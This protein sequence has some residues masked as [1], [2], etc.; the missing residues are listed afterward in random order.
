MGEEEG[1][2]RLGVRL[3]ASLHHTIEQQAREHHRSLNSEIITLL[4][5]GLR[6]NQLLSE[7][8]QLLSEEDSRTRK[9]E[10]RLNAQGTL[11][12]RLGTILQTLLDRPPMMLDE[13]AEAIRKIVNEEEPG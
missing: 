6:A 11:L 9:I 8:K 10:E 7:T 5:V 2:V 3:P 12:E 4:G 13:E 1:T